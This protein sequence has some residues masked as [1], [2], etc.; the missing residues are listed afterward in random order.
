MI[1]SAGCLLI[2]VFSA[3]Y[4]IFKLFQMLKQLQMGLRA[5]MV[6]AS[7]V[8]SCFCYM[9]KKQ[10]RAVRIPQTTFIT[11]LNKLFGII[12]RLYY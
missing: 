11:H 12:K 2:F 6:L 3:N 5:F 8:W 1:H 4:I 9:F 10:I 7:K